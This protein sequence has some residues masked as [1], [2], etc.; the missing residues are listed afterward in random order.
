MRNAGQCLD[1]TQS[2]FSSGQDSG[3]PNQEFRVLGQRPLRL[4]STMVTN[5]GSHIYNRG[6]LLGLFHDPAMLKASGLA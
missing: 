5:Q 3:S 4:G 2:W 1:H 6:T